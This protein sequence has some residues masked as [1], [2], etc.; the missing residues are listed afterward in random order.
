MTCD[1]ISHFDLRC[2]TSAGS[3]RGLS[4]LVTV[5]GQRSLGSLD[6]T[7]YSPPQ[8]LS[9]APLTAPTKGGSIIRFTGRNLGLADVRSR[10]EVMMTSAAGDN[11][12]YGPDSVH[13]ETVFVLNIS[14]PAGAYLSGSF[15]MEVDGLLATPCPPSI[16]EGD[17]ANAL[18]S[19]SPQV[20]ARPCAGIPNVH[21][22]HVYM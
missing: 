4:W 22:A 5:R 14:A 21:C 18:T 1:V 12:Y 8:L 19:I 15:R 20:T 13:M 11:M 2:K 10:L 9:A 3:G 6:T 17:L 16:M 7:F